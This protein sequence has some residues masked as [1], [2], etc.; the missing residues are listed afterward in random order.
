MFIKLSI[1][2]A[3]NNQSISINIH[4]N[5]NVTIRPRSNDHEICDVDYDGKSYVIF[6]TA[7]E[8]ETKINKAIIVEQA[9]VNHQM[10][11]HLQ[12]IFSE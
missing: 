6:E 12:D 11:K 9:A 4:P 2:T 10:R 7:D 8:I 1:D 3:A 5:T